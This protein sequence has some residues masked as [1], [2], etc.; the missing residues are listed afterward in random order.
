MRWKNLSAYSPCRVHCLDGSTPVLLADGRHSPLAKLV[1]GDR[2]YGTTHTGNHRRL[3]ATEVTAHRTT[4]APAQ[5]LLIEGGV[6]LVA[7]ADHR[8]LTERGWKHLLPAPTGSPPRPYLTPAD[9]LMAV[10]DPWPPGGGTGQPDVLT[11]TIVGGRSSVRILAIEP[12]DAE[13]ELFDIATGTG[14]YVA[15]GLISHACSAS[16]PLS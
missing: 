10:P 9:R 15:A 4:H 7:S 3:V 16:P 11:G 14:D 8:F 13:L 5:R 2:I 1:I 12:L 6:E